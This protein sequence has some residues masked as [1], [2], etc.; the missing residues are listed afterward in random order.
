MTCLK[1]CQACQFS[2]VGV[3]EDDKVVP[4]LPEALKLVHLPHP[5]V[6]DP[7]EDEQ[8]GELALR[9]DHPDRLVVDVGVVVIVELG[10][11]LLFLRIILSQDS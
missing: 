8:G 4:P 7:L 3:S 2:V 10:G 11:G 1:I 6:G 5:G 9:Q